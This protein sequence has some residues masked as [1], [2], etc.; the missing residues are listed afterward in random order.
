MTAAIGTGVTF[1]GA[2][3]GGNR[4]VIVDNNG[5]VGY[6]AGMYIN[7]GYTYIGGSGVNNA[8][9][10]LNYIDTTSS[11]KSLIFG[12]DNSAYN[13]GEVNFNYAG[14]GSASNWLGLG[15]YAYY[16]VAITAAGKMGIGIGSQPSYYMDIYTST[17]SG[18][19][20]QTLRLQ[21]NG[22]AGQQAVID[23]NA[24]GGRSTPAVRI[25]AID[26]GN[27]SAHL[28]FS[29]APGGSGSTV[30]GERM[31]ITN[32]GSTGIGTANPVDA[33]GGATQCSIYSQITTG[34][35]LGIDSGAKTGGDVVTLVKRYTGN[36]MIR[37][38]CLPNAYNA[39]FIYFATNSGNSNPGTIQATNA[40][41]M[42]YG[43]TSDY[44]LKSNVVP[45]S[46]SLEFID[47]L[48]PVNFTFNEIPTEIVAGLI[49]HELQEFIPHAVT[50]VK[51][52]VDENGKMRTQNVDVSF[53]VPYLTAA[54]KD[55]AAQ[56]T[57][58][59]SQL[60]TAQNDIDLLE[61]RLA[62]IEA[63]ISTDTSAD[64]TTTS[65]GTRADALLAQA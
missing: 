11:Y 28:A 32:S 10:A 21:G 4:N 35:T 7:Q 57:D 40:L 63:L 49:A 51:D 44:R 62:A 27:Q 20:Y 29:T 53:I 48:R 47:K 26:D 39:L 31:R 50:G 36:Y 17:T 6:N 58:L 52:D 14:A 16:P 1:T 65:T 8:A 54:V 64:T 13:A 24:W 61:S 3:G 55:L 43:S 5:T 23:M 41:T 19:V 22:G 30:L 33:F 12:R 37:M 56:N 60:Q 45:L 46:N 18:S 42:A 25:A 38:D 59:K 9:F 34:A 2:Y 15:F